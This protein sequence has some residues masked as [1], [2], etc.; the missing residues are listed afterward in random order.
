MTAQEK[1]LD[2]LDVI[3]EYT[4][5]EYVKLPKQQLIGLTEKAARFLMN[6]EGRWIP[7]SVMACNVDG[8]LFVKSWFYEKELAH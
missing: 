8:E 1:L 4:K 2:K 3:S 6:G 5:H 7:I